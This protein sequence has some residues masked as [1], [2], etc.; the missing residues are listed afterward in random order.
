MT[1]IQTAKEDSYTRVDDTLTKNSV[2][3]ATVIGLGDEI[4]DLKS[5][6][7]KIKK[8]STTQIAVPIGLTKSEATKFEMA[9][10][11]VKFILRAKVKARKLGEL[12]L[13]K[14]LDE[15]HTYY[16]K[17]S[18]L[19]VVSKA[20]AA[21]NVLNDNKTI[22]T[23]ITPADITEIDTKISNFENAKDEPIEAQIVTKAA[24][25]DLL[26]P[27][28]KSADIV[29]ENILDLVDS[30]VGKSQPAFTNEIKLDAILR[31]SGA[32]H[33]SVDFDVLDDADETPLLK[34]EVQDDKNAKIYKPGADH[35]TIIPSHNPGYF[36]FNIS[37]PGYQKVAFGAQL[38]R[39]VINHFTIRLKKNPE[40]IV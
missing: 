13:L 11:V 39:A 25:T 20:K 16:I 26:P 33:T 8:A 7:E 17:G 12:T 9:D 1:K 2:I 22:L 34:A 10:T 31:V 24:G 6:I 15:S 32:R 30:Y 14:Q 19:E 3:A 18:K 28:F 27:L 37:C 36:L 35:Q 38:N 4:T 21:R 5:F 40:S 23:I 29:I